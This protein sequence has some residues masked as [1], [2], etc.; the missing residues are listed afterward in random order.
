RALAERDDTKEVLKALAAWV[1]KLDEED[2]EYDHHRVE[3]LW[4]YQSLDVIEPALLKSVLRAK[5]PDARAAATAV[6]RDWHGRVERPLELLAA[7]VAD[8]HPRVRLEAVIA[9]SY[10][11]SVRAMELAAQA[12]DRPMDPFLTQA[13]KQTARALQ[14]QW[15]PALEAGKL[16][17]G[18]NP[19]RLE[20]VLTAAGSRGVVKPL[21]N[22]L[23][24]GK[25]PREN[26]ANAV[27]VIA[28]VGNAGEL[29]QLWQWAADSGDARL[30]V[31][32]LAELRRAARARGANPKGDLRRFKALLAGK[33]EGLRLEAVRLAGTWSLG[34]VR[35]ELA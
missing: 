3:A 22:L 10:F 13:L 17:F 30:H 18:G 31:R 24:A 14:P 23:K 32:T 16:T 25:V 1:Q 5:D 20:F 29:G 8:E 34:S 2:P 15:L 21:L 35:G 11:P 28:A 12:V 27:A 19:R 26:R 9:L 6:L 33:Y 7:Q 4:A